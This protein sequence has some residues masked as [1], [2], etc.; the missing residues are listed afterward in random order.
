ML[1]LAGWVVAAAAL[2]AGH[3]AA[4]AVVAGVPRTPSGPIAVA[5]IASSCAYVALFV[6]VGA[7]FQRAALKRPSI[8]PLGREAK[9]WGRDPRRRPARFRRRRLW[10]STR[11]LAFADSGLQC[12]GDEDAE[13]VSELEVHAEPEMTALPAGRCRRRLGMCAMTFFYQEAKALENDLARANG[14]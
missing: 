11:G 4:A 5:T 8:D 13:A 1:W 2:D 10:A 9:R 12:H 3:G 7:A 14:E 6:L